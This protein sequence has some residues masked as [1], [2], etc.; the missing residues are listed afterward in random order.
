MIQLRGLLLLVL[1]SYSVGPYLKITAPTYNHT[2]N[3]EWLAIFSK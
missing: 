3:L 2:V 1:V